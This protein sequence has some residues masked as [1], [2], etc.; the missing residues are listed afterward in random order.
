MAKASI[1]SLPGRSKGRI[2]LLVLFLALLYIILPQI[3]NFSAS[4][5]ALRGARL[6]LAIAA[7]LLLALTF[8]FA[9]AVYQS[10]A[11]HLRGVEY[12]HTLLVQIASGFT[13]RLLPAGLVN[14]LG[15]VGHLLL[16]GL[17][18]AVAPDA[19]TAR[20]ELPGFARSWLLLA[21]ALL[22]IGILALRKVR[23]YMRKMLRGMAVYAASYRKHPEKLLTALLYSLL[24]T[25]AYVLIFYLCVYS[26]GITMRLWQVFAVFTVGVLVGTAT[27]TPGGLVGVEA[28]LVAGLLAY[29]AGSSPALAAVLLYRFLTYWLPLLPGLV[30]FLAIRRRYL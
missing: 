13:N 6:N 8:A 27:P 4:I 10:L 29:G 25:I 20:L 17:A 7:F 28:G 18:V 22:C 15:V 19:F 21:V 9:A 26:L 11:L 30:V 1:S 3:G 23:H 12:R 24:L 2:V 16:L 14:T 5:T